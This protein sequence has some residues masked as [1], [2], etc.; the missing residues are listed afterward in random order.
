MLT[1]FSPSRLPSQQ[2]CVFICKTSTFSCCPRRP[3]LPLSLTR[4]RAAEVAGHIL[5]P[6]HWSRLPPTAGHL[7]RCVSTGSLMR[8]HLGKSSSSLCPSRCPSPPFIE[9]HSTTFSPL[10][11]APATCGGFPCI[12]ECTEHRCSEITQCI[13]ASVNTVTAPAVSCWR[14]GTCH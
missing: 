6:C 11:P 13:R 3:G 1:H 9:G 4:I 14:P 10:S 8:S 7:L 12:L 5:G 2:P